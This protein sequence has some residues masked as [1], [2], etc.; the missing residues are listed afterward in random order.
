MTGDACMTQDLF[1]AGIGPGTY[2]SDVE[3]AQV[4]LDQIKEFVERY[5]EVEPVFGHDL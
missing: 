3:Q 4:A 1:D 2:S 5:P